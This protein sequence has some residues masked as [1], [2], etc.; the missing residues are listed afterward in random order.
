[1]G[2][3]V[4]RDGR[5]L[6]VRRGHPPSEGLW[7]IPGGSVELGE[8]LQEAAEREIMEE[9]GLTIR[10]GEPVYTFDVIL[11]DDAGRVQFHY[12]IV[13]L[14]ADYVRGEVHSGDDARDARWVTS[15]ELEKLPVNQTTLE[16]LKKL[17]H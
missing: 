1:V 5:V 3:I 6:L 7:A 12:V 8:T 13:D 14:L 2:A 16:L 10:A 9:T 17:F 4:V 11:R 15:G